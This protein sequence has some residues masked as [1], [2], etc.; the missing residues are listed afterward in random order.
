[1]PDTFEFTIP[2]PSV[3]LGADRTSSVVVDVTS[4]L[5][6][7][8]VVGAE[9]VPGEGADSAWFGTPEPFE[10]DLPSGETL[11]TTIPINVPADA[12]AGEYSFELR[13]YAVDDPQRDFTNSPS[14]SV[15]VP[16]P[17][18]PGG[19]PSWIF[20]VIGVLV[21]LVL[22]FAIYFLF[23]RSEDEPIFPEAPD[24]IGLTLAEA[25]NELDEEQTLREYSQ[26]GVGCVLL[27]TPPP[28]TPTLTVSVLVV[29]CPTPAPNV[30]TPNVLNDL[31]DTVEDFCRDLETLYGEDFGDN[32]EWA[33]ESAKMI[34]T[35]VE[36][37]QT[38]GITVESVVGETVNDAIDTLDGQ[39]FLPSPIGDGTSGAQCAYLQHPFAGFQAESG[40]EIRFVTTQCPGPAESAQDVVISTTIAAD[41]SNLCDVALPFCNSI[42]SSELGQGFIGSEEFVVEMN[43]MVQQFRNAFTGATVPDVREADLGVALDLLEAKG[44]TAAYATPPTDGNVFVLRC[45]TVTAQSPNPGVLI[46]TLDNDVVGLQL[47]EYQCGFI[48]PEV[49]EIDPEV[50]DRRVIDFDFSG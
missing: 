19:I 18:A 17:A 41:Y 46:S 22:A 44:L 47:E 11:R 15:T 1:M 27:Q 35:F 21:A 13:A 5:G 37:F 40:D 45:F 4:R 23:F 3:E 49:L 24:L 7:H 31:C 30:A 34:E 29:Q 26:N 8:G 39:G 38:D 14:I 9:V 33:E 43:G 10:F 48:F 42:R 2:K 50:F 12:V 32:E 16:P 28:D 25:Q 6:R 20:I 36:T